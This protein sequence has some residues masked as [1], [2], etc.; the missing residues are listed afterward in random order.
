MRN[1]VNCKHQGC[2]NVLEGLVDLQLNSELNEFKLN[3][4]SDNVVGLRYYF[5]MYD[6]IFD[7]D[8]FE[9]K[10][11]YCMGR[12]KAHVSQLDHYISTGKVKKR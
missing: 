12:I 4:I 1:F 7:T 9:Q 10:R 5:R 11:K 6:K 8:N 2:I 3:E